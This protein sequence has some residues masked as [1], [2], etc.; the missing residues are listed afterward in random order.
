MHRSELPDEHRVVIFKRLK[1][2][3]KFVIGY[4]EAMSFLNTQISCC[5]CYKN[6]LD[7]NNSPVMVGKGKV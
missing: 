1:A 7:E 2:E 5:R 6:S 4:F 3:G